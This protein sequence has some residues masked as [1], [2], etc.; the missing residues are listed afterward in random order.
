MRA[1]CIYVSQRLSARL[2]GV[3]A[4][5][6]DTFCNTRII[7]FSVYIGVD[8]CV[9][10][11]VRL[12]LSL[13]LSTFS[14]MLIR[15]MLAS[16]LYKRQ[17][18]WQRWATCHIDKIYGRRAYFLCRSPAPPP[19]PHQ[20]NVI[21]DKIYFVDKDVHINHWQSPCSRKFE[22]KDNDSLIYFVGKV[23]HRRINHGSARLRNERK[24]V[25]GH[26]AK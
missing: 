5:A 22:P 16:I 14:D 2:G 15:A 6:C 3:F 13:S 21:S 9:S 25:C 10:A 23:S 19:P 26:S 11:L 18:T 12:A 1:Y 17:F 8:F 4:R 24:L 20:P 7:W